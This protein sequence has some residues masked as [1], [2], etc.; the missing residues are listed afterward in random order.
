MTEGLGSAGELL[1][2]LAVLGLLAA[3][4][5][6]LVRFGRRLL[7]PRPS[8]PQVH[9]APPDPAWRSRP[10]P[11]DIWWADVPFSDGSGGKVR[12]CLVIRTYSKGVEVLKITSQDKSHRMNCVS[13]PTAHWDRQARKDSWLDLDAPY[14]IDDGDFQRRAG[15]CDDR[16]WSLVRRRHRTGWVHSPGR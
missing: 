6:F 5:Y 2:L 13:I 4:A 11:G 7:A 15:A 9:E 14:L 10:R 16:T 3:V 12:P 8:G 1:G